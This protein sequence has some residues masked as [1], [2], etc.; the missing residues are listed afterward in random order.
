MQTTS[1]AKKLF[2]S[3]VIIVILIALYMQF[4]SSLKSEADTTSPLSSS[5]AD[6]YTGGAPGSTDNQIAQDTAFLQTLTSL[7]RIKIDASVFSNKSFLSLKNNEVMIESVVAGRPNPFAVI[8]LA[9]SETN[10]T[11]ASQVVTETPTQVTATSALFGG[12]TSVSASNSYFEYGT[13]ATLGKSTTPGLLS[14][15]GTFNAKVTGLTPKT[16]YYVRAVSKIA[17]V[18]TYGEVISFNTN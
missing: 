17:G 9:T 8:D 4:S 18:L 15:V 7:T 1:T 2:K 10:T 13:T 3:T 16:E 5:L 12:T 6:S 14:L 11:K